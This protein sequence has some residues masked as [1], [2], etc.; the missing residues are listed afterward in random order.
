[1][2]LDPKNRLTATN[3]ILN[4]AR[5]TNNTAGL[6][7]DLKGYTTGPI[8]VLVDI[9]T[10]T[11][12]DNDG[13]VTVQLQSATTNSAAA[14]TNVSGASVTTT[15]NTTATSM[16]QLDPRAVSRYLF[17]RIILAGTNAVSYPVSAVVIGEKQVQSVS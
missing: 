15:N 17:G 4:A 14:A 10:K 11:G 3:L 6:G 16:I 5:A 7:V 8:A 13:S 12:G 2:A 1:M 9:G